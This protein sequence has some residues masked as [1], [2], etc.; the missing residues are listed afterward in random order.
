[1]TRTRILFSVAL[2]CAGWGLGVAAGTATTV[3]DIAPGVAVLGAGGAGVSLAGGAETLYYN[4]AGLAELPGMSLSSFFSSHFGEASYSSLSFTFRNFGVGALLL[5]SGSIQGYDGN[6]NPTEL[7]GYSSS[8]YVFGFGLSSGDLPFLRVLPADMAFGGLLKVITS[9]IG[10]VSGSGFALDLG[11]R[12]VFSVS[13]LGPISVSNV[14]LGVTAVNVF[15]RMSYDDIDDDLAMDLRVGV[16][17][18][19]L[20]RIT[21]AADLYLGGGARLGVSFSPVTSLALRLGLLSSGAL[22][23]TAGLGVNVQGFLI[24]YAYVSHAVGASHRVSL[25]L[26]FSGLNL[27]GLGQ[28]LRRFLP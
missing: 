22:S 23:V 26:D 9:K 10:A 18:R 12:T 4:P 20:E 24:D 25:T 3:L 2:L 6:G 19:L 14:A 16:S 1:V 27:R 11:F 13:S 7:L 21:V 17:A 28:S 5:N 15:G 8:A